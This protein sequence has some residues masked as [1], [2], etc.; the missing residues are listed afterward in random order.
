MMINR[1]DQYRCKH[2]VLLQV[3][4]DFDCDT[5][6]V[7]DTRPAGS[8]SLGAASSGLVL[9]LTGRPGSQQS[10]RRKPN[11]GLYLGTDEGR[12]LPHAAASQER[13]AVQLPASGKLLAV[14]AVG[15]ALQAALPAATLQGGLKE[16]TAAQAPG[17][18]HAPQKVGIPSAGVGIT[19][20]PR[21]LV[22]Q[23]TCLNN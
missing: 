23:C 9:V 8:A 3:K 15:R 7:L 10:S 2:G 4:T 5:S 14:P 21:H 20:Q 18:G 17:E 13:A 6:I 11:G 1:R 22:M 16:L 19:V 12:V